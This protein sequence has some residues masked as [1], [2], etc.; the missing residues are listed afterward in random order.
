M[1]TWLF[2]ATKKNLDRVFEKVVLNYYWKLLAH[3][4]LPY[5]KRRLCD[6][7]EHQSCDRF[8]WYQ[9]TRFQCVPP[10]WVVPDFPPP[11]NKRSWNLVILS[12]GDWWTSLLI[13]K[14]CLTPRITPN[15]ANHDPAKLLLLI[16]FLVVYTVHSPKNSDIDITFCYRHG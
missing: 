4:R 1:T 13:E 2:V 8:F 14:N 6:Q 16:E 10:K 9:V 5:Q 11:I 7:R 15:T 3:F 12:F